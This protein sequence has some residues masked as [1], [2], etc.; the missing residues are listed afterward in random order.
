MM[1]LATPNEMETLCDRAPNHEKTEI[2][3]AFKENRLYVIWNGSDG[4]LG[5]R[6][7]S[8]DDALFFRL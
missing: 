7:M 3:E 6:I 5:H 8:R 1:R 4:M 2:R